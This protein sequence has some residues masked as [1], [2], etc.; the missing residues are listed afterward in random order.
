MALKR[1]TMVLIITMVHP[2]ITLAKTFIV[3]DD[4]GWRTGFNY[5]NWTNGKQFRTGDE[6]GKL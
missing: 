3:G 1:L 5:Q 2:T 6:M 4:S